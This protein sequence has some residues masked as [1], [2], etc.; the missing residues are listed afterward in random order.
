MDRAKL[1]VAV[2]KVLSAGKMNV[3]LLP[4]EDI[5]ALLDAPDAKEAALTANRESFRQYAK[6]AEAENKLL[7]E[8][9]EKYGRHRGNCNVNFI[10]PESGGH[11]YKDCTCGLKEA[12]TQKGGE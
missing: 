5:I 10:E 7:R 1:R 4:C 6:A 3:M 11:F 2:E 12:L 8:A 9:L